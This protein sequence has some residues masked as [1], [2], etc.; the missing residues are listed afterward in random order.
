MTH[1]INLSVTLWPSDEFPHFLRFATDPRVALVRLNSAM[2][3]CDELDSALDMVAHVSAR[4]SLVPLY[5]DVKGRQLR[6]TEVI[7]NDNF[8]EIRLNHPITVDTPTPVLFKAGADVALLQEVCDDGYH[9]KFLDGPKYKVKAGESIHIRDASLVVGG[10]QFTALELEKIDKTRKAGF[11]NY[12]LSYVECQKDVDEFIE[13]VGED[14]EIK[15]KI[16]NKKGLA[17][18]RNEFKKTPNVSLV[19]ARGDLYVELDK[20]HQILEACKLIVNRDPSAIVGSR[21]LLSTIQEA[22]P[23][24]ADFSEL[25]WLYDIGYRNFMLCD[26]LCLKEPLL[27]RAVGAFDAFRKSYGRPV[28]SRSTID[29]DVY[30]LNSMTPPPEKKKSWWRISGK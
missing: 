22:V 17:Y 25:A 9:L 1:D 30:V 15:L 18:V 12:F 13:L 3:D 14:C 27:A 19:T 2:M 6:I 21:M 24:C 28:S 11:K 29:S 16:E 5:F 26:E 8:L 20:P 7:P 23:S 4:N 10:D